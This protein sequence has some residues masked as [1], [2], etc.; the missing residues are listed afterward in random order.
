[1][2]WYIKQLL[3]LTYWATYE[4]DG[5]TY[6]HIWKM[7]FGRCYDQTKFEINTAGDFVSE[8]HL[9]KSVTKELDGM[10]RIQ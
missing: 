7:W 1:M 10:K 2:G 9:I 5:K 6:F 4:Q 3:P 8:E